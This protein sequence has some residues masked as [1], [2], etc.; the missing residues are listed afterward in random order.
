MN[1]RYLPGMYL[2]HYIWPNQQKMLRYFCNNLL[3]QIKNEV[4]LFYEVGVGC[5]IY[6]QKVL[7]HIP[8][9]K[10]IGID[11]SD[12]SLDFTCRLLKAH[13]MF[14]RYEIY[15]RDLIK[16]P[17]SQKADF[18]VN[19]E[20]LEH[21]EDPATFIKSLYSITR[22]GGWG[23]I[24]AAVNAAHIDH[25]YLY[26]SPQEVQ[27]QIE[28]AG[29]KVIDMQIAANYPEKPIEIRPTVAGFFV[30]K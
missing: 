21:L 1:E 3:P 25:I 23:Y 8:S 7:Q 18:V 29:W 12:Y 11:I 2:T 14:D 16:N 4:S 6:S 17:P 15:N 30:K 13:S 9:A 24:T 27:D 22:E 20:V 19:Q 26:R 10:G 28:D 5:G